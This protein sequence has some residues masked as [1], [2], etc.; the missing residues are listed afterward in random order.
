MLTF[1]DCLALC[2][3]TEKEVEAISG[4]EHLPEIIAAEYGNYLVHTADG[5]VRIRRMIVDD[6]DTARAHGDLGQMS[7]LIGVLRRFIEAHPQ[8]RGVQS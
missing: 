8:S 5:Q 1:E 3:L 7:M 2:E 6:I 4:H